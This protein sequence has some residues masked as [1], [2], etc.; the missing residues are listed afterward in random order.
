L[1]ALS[2][3]CA[4]DDSRVFQFTEPFVEPG[5]P[6]AEE[7]QKIVER[8]TLPQ[9]NAR[10][11][12]MEESIFDFLRDV[13]L[14]RSPQNLDAEGSRAQRAVRSEISADHRAGY[15]KGTRRYAFLHLQSVASAK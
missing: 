12:A 11:P 1:K 7:D 2:R 14:L 6:V 4:R 8:A 9:P 3:T 10:N 15:G 5:Q 13:L